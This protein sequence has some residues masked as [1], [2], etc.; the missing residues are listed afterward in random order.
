M[1][2]AGG[3]PLPLYRRGNRGTLVGRRGP[4]GAPQAP[5]ARR[6]RPLGR[7][8]RRSRIGNRRIGGVRAAPLA[9]N[10]LASLGLPL[11]GRLRP[12]PL[13]GVGVRGGRGWLSPAGGAAR[14]RLTWAEGGGAAARSAGGVAG[15]ASG[16][17]CGGEP[18]QGSASERPLGPSE[19]GV[20]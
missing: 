10:L 11:P 5:G 17:T 2:A 13:S 19:S 3:A 15:G 7:A 18:A 20:R 9:Q 6:S 1:R 14:P 4:R 8:G 12:R 16:A